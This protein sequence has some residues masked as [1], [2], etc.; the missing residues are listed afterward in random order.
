ML[1]RILQITYVMIVRPLNSQPNGCFLLAS[2]SYKKKT[3]KK[4][5]VWFYT[6]QVWKIQKGLSSSSGKLNC[7]WSMNITTTTTKRDL[8]QS[9]MQQELNSVRLRFLFK[10]FFSHMVCFPIGGY[11]CLFFLMWVSSYS[12]RYFL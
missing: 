7:V 8:G 9:F 2:D 12:I 6:W 3:N 11:F 10:I 5:S 4:N 1:P